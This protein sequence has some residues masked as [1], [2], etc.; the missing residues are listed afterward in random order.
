MWTE[1]LVNGEAPA[2]RDGHSAS[3]AGSKMIVFGGRGGNGTESDPQAGQGTGTSLLNDEWEID[4][5]PSQHVTV[6]TNA[7]TVSGS[8][9]R[10]GC[11][12]MSIVESMRVAQAGSVEREV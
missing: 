11:P 8:G 10:R 6:A 2:A 5:D 1:V 9:V 4:L 12:C 7:S 3:V